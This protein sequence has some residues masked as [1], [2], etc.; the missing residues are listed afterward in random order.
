MF[1]YRV[2]DDIVAMAR[3]S[4]HLIEKYDIVEQFQR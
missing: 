4:N 1:F 3:P 2:T